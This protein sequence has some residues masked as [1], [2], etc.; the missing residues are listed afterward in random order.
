M[1][2]NQTFSSRTPWRAGLAVPLVF[3]LC[4]APLAAWSQTLETQSLEQRGFGPEGQAEPGQW[5]VNL[6]AGVGVVPDFPGANAYRARVLP[7]FLV[8]YGKVLFFGPM[9]LGV[10]VVNA[11]GFRAGP[12]IGFQGGRNEG[13]DAHLH[14]LGDISASLTGGFFA[15]YQSGPV[16]VSATV[17]QALTHTDNG[18]QG[19]VQLDLLVPMPAR[20]MLLSFGPDIEFA[21]AR[22]TQTWFGVSAAQ[23]QQS[24]LPTYQAGAGVRDF[25]VHAN[26]SY[27]LDRHIVLRG[28][29]S[30]KE[31]TGDAADSPVVQ[32]KTQAT[33]GIGVAY[34]F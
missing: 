34:H 4:A 21:N 23:A 3:F 24:G 16:R 14:G 2:F 33:A 20:K 27:L 28:F 15:A 32:S 18:L 9:G 26:A 13:D 30:V 31:F 5:N 7:F 19:L 1:S 22:Y 25:G 8:N 10:N 17:R 29:A 6:G 11:N 12:L